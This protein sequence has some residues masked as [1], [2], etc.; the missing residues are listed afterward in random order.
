MKNIVIPAVLSIVAALWLLPRL[1]PAGEVTRAVLL[2][3]VRVE[4]TER[5]MDPGAVRET[6]IRP[7]DQVIVFLNE[8]EYERVDPDTGE[9]T[10]TWIANLSEGGIGLN[11]NAPLEAGTP[12]VIYL[13]G[14]NQTGTVTLLARVIHSTKETDGSWRVG[15][16]FTSK[17]QPEMLDT[18]L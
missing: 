7:T 18:L 11:M 16:E 1:S 2:E 13:K 3:N 14:P 10:E 6:Q 5:V 15:C 8:A 12:L 17:L 9:K 4:V